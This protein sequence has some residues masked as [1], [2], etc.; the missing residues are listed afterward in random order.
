GYLPPHLPCALAEVEADT[1][2]ARHSLPEHLA[3]KT[4]AA[5]PVAVPPKSDNGAYVRAVSTEPLQTIPPAVRPARRVEK[6]K[7]SR[8]LP[9][10]PDFLRREAEIEDLSQ[11]ENTPPEAPPSRESNANLLMGAAGACMLLC[12]A[13]GAGFL[14]VQPIIERIEAT[15]PESAPLTAPETT[16]AE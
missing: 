8:V 14:L 6:D 7:S 11:Y 10:R 15:P 2:L 4:I 5:R 13:F 16:P 3:A 1:P 12:V 9:L